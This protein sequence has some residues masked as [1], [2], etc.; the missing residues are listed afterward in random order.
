MSAA[1]VARDPAAK[2]PIR[3]TIDG[4]C[5]SARDA[6]VRNKVIS[7]QGMI[8]LLI[9]FSPVFLPTD[10]WLLSSDN[11]MRSCQ[12]LRQNRQTN[13]LRGFQIDKLWLQ[14]AQ[15]DLRGEAREDR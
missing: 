3:W 6:V 13:L 14:A 4:C 2:K 9:R 11:F 1:L 5:A 7:S 12:H 15:K 8:F 10:H